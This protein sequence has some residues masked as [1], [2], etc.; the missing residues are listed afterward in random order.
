MSPE[1]ACKCA[2]EQIVLL[3]SIHMVQFI[4]WSRFGDFSVQIVVIPYK[5]HNVTQKLP[6]HEEYIYYARSRTQ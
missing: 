3:L 2:L 1:S 6:I 4:V 5:K